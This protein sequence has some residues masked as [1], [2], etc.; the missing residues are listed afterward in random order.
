MRAEFF[1]IRLTEPF[2]QSDECLLNNF[3][4]S[5]RVEKV[6]SA[7]ISAENSWSVIVFYVDQITENTTFNKEV[8]GRGDK[9]SF[10][11]DVE[12]SADEKYRYDCLRRWRS[13]KAFSIQVACFVIASNRELMAIAKTRIE[14]PSDLL[15]I[16][17]FSDRKVE[18]YGKEIVALLNSI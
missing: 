14:Q 15:K 11:I 17:G 2:L 5:V 4:D 10:D 12:L 8:F 1:K 13:D 18:A 6:E 3:L 7:F 16:K 9:I